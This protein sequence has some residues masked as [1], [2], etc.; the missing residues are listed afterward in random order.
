MKK[1]GWREMK[2]AWKLSEEE[3]YGSEKAGYSNVAKRRMPVRSSEG[4][5]SVAEENMKR[6]CS[7]GYTAAKKIEA[8]NRETRRRETIILNNSAFWRLLYNQ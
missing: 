6:G 5:S 4:F 8:L 2:K 7:L 3:K 1:K